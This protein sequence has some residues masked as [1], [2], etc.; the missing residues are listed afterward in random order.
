VQVATALPLPTTLAGTTVSV[1]DSAGRERLAPLFFVSPGQV[2]YLIPAGLAAGSATVTV[3][4]G[5]GAVSSGLIRL[6]TVAPGLFSANA[7][8]QGVAA[9]VALRVKA[10]GQQFFE[11]VARADGTGRNV[12][13]PLDFG[14]PGDQLYLLLFGTGLRGH[15]GLAQVTAKLGG[16]DAPVLFAGAQGSLAGLD[17]VNLTLPRV[18][19]GRGE[20]DVVLTVDGQP[21]NIVKIAFK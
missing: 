7:N 9:A 17:Q 16:V 8:G 2:N 10:N 14:E 6:E 21:A 11:P 12:A 1:K 3:T 15:S 4:S 19:A 20:V 5:S 18:L 13:L